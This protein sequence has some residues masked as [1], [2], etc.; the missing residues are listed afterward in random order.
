MK[1]PPKTA[2]FL[3]GSDDGL[4]AFA[5]AGRDVTASAHEQQPD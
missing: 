3:F 1:S 4:A 2:G 5:G